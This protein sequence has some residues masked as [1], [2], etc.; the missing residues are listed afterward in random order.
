LKL[1]I[2]CLGNTSD[3]HNS[4]CTRHSATI[5]ESAVSSRG[6]REKAPSLLSELAIEHTPN[7]SRRG[8]GYND[9]DV[10]KEVTEIAGHT[11][12]LPFLL[13]V[14]VAAS[15]SIGILIGLE[16]TWAHKEAGVRSFAIATLQKRLREL[17]TTDVNSTF[18]S[19]L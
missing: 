13:A 5:D 12:D 17:S 7:L 4:C 3:T 15:A 8:I 11:M 18:Y 2:K 9:I 14:K 6:E 19:T 1:R 16:R 10:Y